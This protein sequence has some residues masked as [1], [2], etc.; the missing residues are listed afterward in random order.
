MTL[1]LIASDCSLMLMRLVGAFSVG[2]EFTL[3]TV[4]I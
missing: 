3:L 2:I 1:A 4:V